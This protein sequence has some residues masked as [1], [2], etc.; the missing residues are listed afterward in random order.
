MNDPGLDPGPD[1]L[2]EVPGRVRDE[3]G[4][5]A[6]RLLHGG[7]TPARVLLCET[8]SGRRV[9]VKV[10]RAG[11]GAVDGHDLGSFLRKPQQ[12]AAIHRDLPGLSP[13]YVPLAGAWQ[14]PG[15]GAYAMPW[16]DGQPP[17]TLLGGGGAASGEFGRTVRLAFEALGEHGY[18]ASRSP[19]P[20]GHGQAAYPGRVRRRLPLL[21]RHLDAA[22]TCAGT[23]RVNGRVIA[24]AGELLA[25]AGRP[26]ARL[27]LQPAALW[28]PVHGDLNLG[29]LLVRPG[30]PGQEPG[31]TVIDPRGI[32]SHF[33]PVYDVA[34][35]LFSLTLFDAAMAGG[36]AIGGG[37]ARE[38]TVRL[39]E[40]D[41]PLASAAAELPGLVAST[42]FFRALD[43]SDPLWRRR[44][45][46]AHAF[47]VLAES[48]CRLS[49]RTH[50]VLP[51]VAAGRAARR[52]LATGLYLSGLLLLDSLLC[53]PPDPEN[54][55][56]AHLACIAEV[57]QPAGQAATRGHPGSRTAARLRCPPHSG[58]RS[59][60]GAGA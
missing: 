18:A 38:Y 21:A 23:V 45:L 50:R 46:Y 60:T 19:A 5:Q 15:W 8:G 53:G 26:G 49:D 31:F 41:P 39:R 30:R 16:V 25:R 32:T 7:G 43:R 33:D 9:V 13:H 57:T 40:P 35:A 1:L 3:L 55:L 17:V 6:A 12:I 14:G 44:L 47:H 54:H 58:P 37:P 59:L 51:G 34:K 4:V 52:E 36:F 10:L 27:A 20:A 24:P 22:L 48:A 29:N 11:A 2:G 42:G 56:D 28:Y